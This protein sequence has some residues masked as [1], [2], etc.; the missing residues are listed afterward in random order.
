MFDYAALARYQS[1]N[2]FFFWK[3]AQEHDFFFFLQFD[4]ATVE[5]SPNVRLV[6]QNSDRR[7]LST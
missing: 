5:T 1:A 4:V 2:I 6:H 7:D 3:S